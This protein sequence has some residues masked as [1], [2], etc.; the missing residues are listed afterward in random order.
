MFKQLVAHL[1]DNNLSEIFQYDFQSLHSTETA[2][3]KVCNDLPLAED[4]GEGSVLL[5]LDLSAAFDTADHN[6]LI[7]RLE[8]WAGITDVAQNW[9]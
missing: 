8:R 6:L 7:A 5:L 9:F 3:L 1:T 4:A 2:L